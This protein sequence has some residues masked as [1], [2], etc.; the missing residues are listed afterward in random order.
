MKEYNRK[1]KK[2]ENITEQVP[3]L[4]KK[5]TCKAGRP[6]NFVLVLPF[7]L[8][9]KRDDYD[10]KTILAYYESEDRICEIQKTEFEF[11]KSLGIDIPRYIFYRNTRY[12]KCDVCGKKEYE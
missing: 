10:T 9:Q 11:Q 6:H 8:T 3:V 2:W 12:Y 1:T 7:S 4:K 5:S